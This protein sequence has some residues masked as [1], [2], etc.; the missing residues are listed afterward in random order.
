[1]ERR[2]RSKSSIVI[3]DDTDVIEEYELEEICEKIYEVKS[4]QT[5]W[6][7]MF[8]YLKNC[9]ASISSTVFNACGIYIMWIL[10][11]Y[12]ASHL[13][14]Y[15]CAPSTIIGFIYSPFIIAA[16]HCKSLR[17]VIFNGAASVDNMWLVFGT[18]LCSKIIIP[19]LKKR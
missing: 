7:D 18:W 1:M 19:K 3:K 11:H 16:P 13:Y 8:V 12:I 9:T 6:V 5:W 2:S 4:Y 10:F 15:F 14:I 17:W